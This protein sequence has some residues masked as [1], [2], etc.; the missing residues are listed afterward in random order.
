MPIR[1]FVA[2]GWL[3]GLLPLAAAGQRHLE[4][5][6]PPVYYHVGQLRAPLLA[7]ADTLRPP[8]RYLPSQSVVHVVGELSPRWVVVKEQ[9]FLYLTPA[10]ALTDYDAADAATPPLDA[11]TH[12]IAYEGVVQVPGATATEL[13][14]RA[15]A[16]M[17]KA[18]DQQNAT[19]VR[20][21]PA[22]GELQLQGSRLTHVYRDY[23]G[24]PRQIYAG[25]VR[26]T[27]TIYVKDGR[28]KYVLTDLV[29]DAQHTAGMQSGGA[30]E[31][32]KATLYGYAG[33]G[34]YQNWAELKTESLRDARHLVASLEE[35]MTLQK[36]RRA[37]PAN[38]F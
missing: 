8:T 15:R 23:Q 17:P 2:S 14:A 35:A 38:E 21:D 33:L 1:F 30:L 6:H 16:W 32:K 34:S 22:S 11:T 4:E 5:V 9:G 25:V 31:Q 29:H 36:P 10:A 19:L 28:Y 12:R 13:L 27:L 18:Y 26:H 7:S 20:D 24:I 37:R 3:L